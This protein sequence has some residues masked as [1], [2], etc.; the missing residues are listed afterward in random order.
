[1]PCIR[2]AS[3]GAARSEGGARRPKID[4]PGGNENLDSLDMLE[5]WKSE[6]ISEPV[7]IKI[8]INYLRNCTSRE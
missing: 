3:R 6:R 4:E 1:M 2:T 8:A 5:K 7:Y